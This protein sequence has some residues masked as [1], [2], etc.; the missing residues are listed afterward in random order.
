ME[1]ECGRP[2]VASEHCVHVCRR[3]RRCLARG[4]LADVAAKSRR[5]WPC[6]THIQPGARCPWSLLN[7]ATKRGYA[8]A[9]QGACVFWVPSLPR[10]VA[11]RATRP[12][13]AFARSILV[14][15]PNL[16][17]TYTPPSAGAAA[18][19]S[20]QVRERVCTRVRLG[21]SAAP[22]AP[23]AAPAAVA[24]LRSWVG[25][26]CRPARAARPLPAMDGTQPF[27][28]RGGCARANP[29]AGCGRVARI[30]WWRWRA[31]DVAKRASGGVA[32]KFLG[33]Q[34]RQGAVI[35]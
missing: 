12:P 35:G 29:T 8:S 6:P 24:V 17:T 14:P 28:G 13:R 2:K 31:R 15:S 32:R 26:A 4:F 1:W 23:S 5:W 27:H 21:G 11:R 10:G 34:A 18:A 33:P 20:R 30:G 9:T 7:A 3:R 16:A 22:C 19:H 25:G